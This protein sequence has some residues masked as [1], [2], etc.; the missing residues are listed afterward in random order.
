MAGW[1]VGPTQPFA[2]RRIGAGA[3]QRRAHLLATNR[4]SMPTMPGW[5]VGPPTFAVRRM[6]L[7]HG[8]D[9][10]ICQ[11]P[12]RGRRLAGMWVPTTFAVCLTVWRTAKR[13]H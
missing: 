11:P 6:G 10:P 2:V 12:A 5:D 1:H 13:L 7:A 4:E 9:G 3:R 8:K